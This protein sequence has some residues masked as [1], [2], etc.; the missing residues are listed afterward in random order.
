MTEVS[1]TELMESLGYPDP[2]ASQRE[3]HLMVRRSQ[4]APP[5]GT[6][7]GEIGGSWNGHF[8]Y[9]GWN[10][11]PRRANAPTLGLRPDERHGPFVPDKSRSCPS[12]AA[13][14]VG[15]ATRNRK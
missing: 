7:S 12:K 8:D 6:S 2:A 4:M 13:V 11:S 3:R 10:R 15:P 1:M 9:G 5:A 14:P